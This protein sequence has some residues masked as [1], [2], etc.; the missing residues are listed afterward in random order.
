MNTTTTKLYIADAL[1]QITDIFVSKKDYEES[2]PVKVKNFF[3][4]HNGVG[5]LPLTR[6]GGEKQQPQPY[7]K[8]EPGVIVKDEGNCGLLEYFNCLCDHEFRTYALYLEVKPSY[9]KIR[10]MACPDADIEWDNVRPFSE[11]NDVAS[12]IYGMAGFKVSAQHFTYKKPGRTPDEKRSIFVK[13]DQLNWLVN[14]DDQPIVKG[15]GGVKKAR[16]EL[17]IAKDGEVKLA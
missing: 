13:A 6:Q 3:A 10:M 7:E 16:I 11:M 15:S 8:E 1:S 4:K 9:V 14:K 17:V 2:L 12:T 5:I